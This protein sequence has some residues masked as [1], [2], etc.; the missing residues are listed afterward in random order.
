M[1]HISETK[2]W[3]EL[4]HGIYGPRQ[5]GAKILVDAK[6][7][8][9]GAGKTTAQCAV[10]ILLSRAFGYELK[11]EDFT[12]AGSEYRRRTRNQP[13]DRPTVVCIDELVGG[14]AGDARRS[15]S[16]ENVDL[17]R[18]WQVERTNQV[19]TIGTLPSWAD[20]DKRLRKLADFRLLCMPKPI[21][22]FVPYKLGTFDF[23]SSSKI[24]FTRL[25]DRI[26]FPDLQGHPAYE[27]ISLKKDLLINSETYDMEEVLEEQQAAAEEEE[28]MS[29]QDIVEE[30]QEEGIDNWVAVHGGNGTQYIDSDLIEVD[31][32]VSAGDARKVKKLLK[33]DTNVQ[34]TTASA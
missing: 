14:G 7:S 13:S 1:K 12:M 2:F 25:D 6:D 21:G 30:I 19:V 15:M 23:D 18:A 32:G 28:T 8:K 24:K 5:G 11:P 9:L 3:A 20:A 22:H 16:N 10:A 26:G 31:F 29:V 17:A 27:Y 4:C 33:R 34:A